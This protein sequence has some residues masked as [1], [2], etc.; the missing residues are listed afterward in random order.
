MP[1]TTFSA[2]GLRLLTRVVSAIVAFYLLLW[3]INFQDEAP[4]AESLRLAK[5]LATRS[6]VPEAQNG[7]IYYAKYLES[8]QTEQPSLSNAQP[9]PDTTVLT[10]LT[11]CQ[12]EQCLAALQTAGAEL[13]ALLFQQQK[14]L[15]SYQIILEYP[16]WQYPVLDAQTRVVPFGPLLHMQQLFLL[17]VWQ[18]VQADQLATAKVMLEQDLTF[19]RQQL[20]QSDH[21]L[22]KSI[23]HSAIQRHWLYASFF[24]QSM[25]QHHFQQLSPAQ[26]QQ[27][28]RDDELSMLSVFAG[29]WRFS[30]S[31]IDLLL[32]QKSHSAFVDWF[33]LG[34]WRPFLQRQALSNM[35]AVQYLACAEPR[36]SYRELHFPWYSWLYNP[37]GKVFVQLEGER[38]SVQS[39]ELAALET[40]RQQLLR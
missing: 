32:Q 1:P 17:S 9:R 28:L 18:K 5:I 34:W 12:S 39:M 2:K 10:S 33:R 23:A 36:T 25:T 26:W 20:Q 14:A 24:K 29:E 30:N 8:T 6:E 22:S 19:W 31:A 13:N 3:M 16:F 37:V 35:F 15:A 21:R 27:P 4:S 38:C 7:F 40:T 11:Q